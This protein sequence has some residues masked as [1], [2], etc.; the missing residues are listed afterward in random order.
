MSPLGMNKL[1]G[2]VMG[3]IAEGCVLNTL[4]LLPVT[5]YLSLVVPLNDIG[6][7]KVLLQQ[8]VTIHII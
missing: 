2:R 8:K 6:G 1:S 3:S 5:Y 4:L 7:G